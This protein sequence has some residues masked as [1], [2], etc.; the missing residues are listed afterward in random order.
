MEDSKITPKTVSDV[1]QATHIALD[2]YGDIFSDFDPSPYQRRLL[3]EDFVK[4]LHRRYTETI[5]GDLVINFALPHAIRSEKVEGIIKKRI[6]E[7][8]KLHHKEL[9]KHSHEKMK[10]GAIRLLIG[11]LVSIA[12]FEI[13]GLS[14]PPIIT[15]LSVFMWFFI[16]SGFEDIFDASAKH[17][18][19][20]IFLEKFMK[21]DYRF[22][23][24]EEVLGSIQKIQE[25]P[26]NPS[27]KTPENSL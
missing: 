17:R 16:W 4:E 13:P 27:T 21:A 24:E 7:Y 15:L 18:H 1:L 23:S 22:I 2:D 26:E 8:F 25:T 11:A 9:D 20:R 19:K 6:K 14:V 3:S 12:V 5:K 10:G